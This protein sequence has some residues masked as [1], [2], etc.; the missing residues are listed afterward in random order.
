MI[1]YFYYLLISLG[2]VF[3]SQSVFSAILPAE[4]FN[5]LA[6]F[7]VFVT[8]V[9][10]LD[11]GFIFAV[12]L[13]LITNYY[14]YL[15]LGT[16]ILIYLALVFMV[17]Y[18]HQQIFINFTFFTNII[19]ILLS[20]L[21]YNALLVSLNFIL[22]LI[23]AIR[24]FIRLDALFYTNLFYQIIFNFILVSLVFVFA[25]AIFKKLNLAILVKR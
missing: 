20:T 7:L 12:L 18:L 19:L 1:K 22:Y 17:D 15:P 6:V 10:G 3:L 5:I 14:S 8:F 11:L 2:L 24:V 9:W 21:L 16:Y 4:N 13:G 25:K 23:G